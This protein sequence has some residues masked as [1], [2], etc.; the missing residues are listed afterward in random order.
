MREEAERVTREEGWTKPAL[1]SM[2]KIDSFLRESQRMNG[3]GS[4]T[5]FGT[6][7]EY[8]SLTSSK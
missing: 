2:H 4:G 8:S 5:Y 3:N 6:L 1:N 7:N